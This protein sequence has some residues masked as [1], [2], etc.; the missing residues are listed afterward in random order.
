MCLKWLGTRARKMLVRTRAGSPWPLSAAP[1]GRASIVW[2]RAG[3]A[4]Q[5]LEATG[6]EGRRRSRVRQNAGIPRGRHHPAFWRMRL[7]RTGWKPLAIYHR[8]YRGEKQRNIKT[9]AR[10]GRRM[11]EAC[12]RSSRSGVFRR[13]SRRAK[14]NVEAVIIGG[15]GFPT[16]EMH[17][18]AAG[19]DSRSPLPSLGVTLL[20][21]NRMQ[22][23]RGL[24]P[25]DCPACESPSGLSWPRRP[26]SRL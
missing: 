19:R 25:R 1:L 22:R 12:R 24:E 5:G 23:T 4:D 18:W 3:T 8:P 15:L 6:R 11:H 14:M 21:S 2:V 13:T 10:A 9:G 16:Q 17:R 20:D 26:S 7:H